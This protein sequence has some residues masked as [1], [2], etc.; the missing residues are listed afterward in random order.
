MTA[1]L[2]TW[3][4]FLL[5]GQPCALPKAPGNESTTAQACPKGDVSLLASMTSLQDQLRI[6]IQTD[7]GFKSLTPTYRPGQTCHVKF[8]SL[9]FSMCKWKCLPWEFCFCFFLNKNEKKITKRKELGI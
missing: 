9:S 2:V 8:L 6:W 4:V 1:V 5:L 3:E 7:L